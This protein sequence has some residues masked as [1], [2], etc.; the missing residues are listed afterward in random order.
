[1]Q[2]RKYRLI[3]E[4]ELYDLPPPPT[5]APPAIAASTERVSVGLHYSVG[6]N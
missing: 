5:S 3:L 4:T 1:M 6:V 2:E